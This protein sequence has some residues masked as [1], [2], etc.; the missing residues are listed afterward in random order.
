[1]AYESVLAEVRA[2]SESGK[3]THTAL[4]NMRAWLTEDRYAEYA[5][6]VA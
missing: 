1:M 2:A 5:P 4:K 6:E 3:I